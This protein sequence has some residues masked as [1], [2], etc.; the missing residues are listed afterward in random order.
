MRISVIFLF[1]FS[2]II[3]CTAQ[4][5][6]L[7]LIP[8]DSTKNNSVYA[9]FKTTR[10]INLQS[11]ETVAS[12]LLDVRVSHRFGAIGRSSNGTSSYHNLWG[13]DE[14]SDIRIAFEYGINDRF[15]AGF[16]RSKY[17]ENWELMGKYRIFRQQRDESVPVAITLFANTA[18]S[19]RRDANL[20]KGNPDASKEFLRRLSYTSQ[21]IFARKFSPSLSLQLMG[22]WVHQN[23]IPDTEKNNLYS[24][25]IGGRVR[26]TPSMAIVADYVYNFRTNDSFYNPLGA[27]IEFETGGHV[28]SLMFSNSIP[29]IENEFIPHTTDTWTEGGIRFSFTISRTFKI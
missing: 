21:I 27:G 28:F 1:L 29:L 17:H 11:I 7:N 13:F 12:H 14:A 16:S 23:Y 6:L 15:T 5:D 22:S 25:C 3:K 10:I 24:A 2:S 20:K 9:T 4:E 26:L 8:V 19:T 18:Y